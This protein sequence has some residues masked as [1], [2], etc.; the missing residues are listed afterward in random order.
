MKV[1]KTI[2]NEGTPKQNKRVGIIFD[3]PSMT[4]QSHRKACNI[5]TIMAKYK[6]TG[7]LPIRQIPAAYGDFSGA[8]DY[9]TSVNRIMMAQEEFMNLP[10]DI[11]K[12]F[13]NSPGKFLEFVYNPENAQ[14]LVDM[15]LAESVEERLSTPQLAAPK[16]TEKEE[17]EPHTGL[18]A[19]N[20][21]SQQ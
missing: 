3:Q 16:E 4:E 2:R 21:M 7:L 6:K 17:P 15:G 11:R 12:Q 9:M 1:N 13:D 14:A 8:E 20:P 5:N 19:P 18:P 10:A